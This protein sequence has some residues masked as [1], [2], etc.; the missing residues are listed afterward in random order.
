[1]KYF[2]SI[3]NINHYYWQIELLI[4]SFKMH[5]LEDD[6][7][8]AIAE[9]DSIKSTPYVMNLSKHKNCISHANAGRENGCLE[10]NRIFSLSKAFSENILT[11][12]FTV[13]HS[14]M[15]LRKPIEPYAS[16][17]TTNTYQVED[18][19][20][21]EFI[22]LDS[23][24][25]NL[26]KSGVLSSLE[27]FYYAHPIVFNHDKDTTESFKENFFNFLLLDM[28]NS[29]IESHEKEEKEKY[30]RFF[31]KACWKRNLLNS[32]G[33][34]KISGDTLACNITDEIDVPFIH[35]NK[36]IPPSFNKHYYK[37]DTCLSENNSPFKQ[38]L[39]LRTISSHASYVASVIESYLEEY[40]LKS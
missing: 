22:N 38:L 36:G 26:I 12:P 16:N 20:I 17:I 11:F 8:I 30:R 28:S 18:K 25:N 13:L 9:N 39:H 29:I 40:N 1:M 4:Q 24:K 34:C 19:E 37:S 14:D 7:I 6:L 27:N 31:E 10:L 21:D 32:S 3:E 33:H 23:I 2:V 35:Y 5:G 15:V